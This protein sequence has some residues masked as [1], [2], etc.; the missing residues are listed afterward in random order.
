MRVDLNYSILLYLHKATLQLH[1]R[2]IDP[3]VFNN[4]HS[5]IR[6]MLYFDAISYSEYSVL[7]ATVSIPESKTFCG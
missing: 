3:K 6:N 1:T 7:K 5:C 2:K 4:I